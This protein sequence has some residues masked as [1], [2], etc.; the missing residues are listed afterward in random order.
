MRRE[1]NLPDRMRREPTRAAVSTGE[2]HQDDARTS[3]E[4]KVSRTVAAKSTCTDLSLSPQQCSV[5]PPNRIK[6]CQKTVV[7]WGPQ[8]PSTACFA[9]TDW[10]RWIWIDGRCPSGR[11]PSRRPSLYGL[12]A[13]PST[14]LLLYGDR[15][16]IAV[17]NACIPRC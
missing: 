2:A 14:I 13:R 9:R 15:P 17:R 5:L 1:H 7:P 10:A 12:K 11:S 3:P 16:T 6:L 4:T 8:H